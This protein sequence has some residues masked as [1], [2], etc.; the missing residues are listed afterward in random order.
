MKKCAGCLNDL[1]MSG[2]DVQWFLCINEQ[3]IKPVSTE[4]N[5]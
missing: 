2:T 3:H 5:K 4:R 1:P